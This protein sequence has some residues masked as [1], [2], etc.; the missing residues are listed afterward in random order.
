MRNRFFNISLLVLI[1][2]VLLS[3]GV[4]PSFASD[5]KVRLESEIMLNAAIKAG[6]RSA[7]EAIYYSSDAP[8]EIR[9][10][11]LR[12]LVLGLDA[13]PGAKTS[14][15]SKRIF[16]GDDQRLMLLKAFESEAAEIRVAAVQIAGAVG[17]KSLERKMLNMAADD[18]NST[19]RVEALRALKPWTRAGH[20]F[21]LDKASSSPQPRVQAEALSNLALL[22]FNETPPE[23]VT[24]VRSLAASSSSPMARVRAMQTLSAWNQLKWETLRGFLVNSGASEELWLD[25]LKLSVNFPTQ[26]RNDL[27]KDV[28]EKGATLRSVWTA[29]QILK[30]SASTDVEFLETL[31]NYLTVSGQKN[32]VTQTIAEFLRKTGYR[33][34]YRAGGWSIS[35]R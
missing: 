31:I 22:S 15:S 19:V 28:V 23:I 10:K 2:A 18:E 1:S 14:K 27:L 12:A 33:V 8:P 20:L 17:E 3:L 35:Y 13:K 16:I 11:A 6:D 5:L 26:Q 24:Q 9:G 29:Y 25:A 21:F 30:D 4:A 7:V 34:D 32:T